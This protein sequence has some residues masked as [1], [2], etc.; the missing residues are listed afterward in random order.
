LKIIKRITGTTSTHSENVSVPYTSWELWYTADPFATGG[1]DSHSASGSQSAVFPQLTIWVRDLRTGKI[2][3]IEPPGGLD[4]DLWQKS[5]DPRPW[6]EKIYSG[7][8]EYNILIT[9]RHVTSYTLEVRV[10]K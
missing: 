9:T 2:V 6:K 1:Q 5:S 8:S 10:A 4:E 7:N 3:E